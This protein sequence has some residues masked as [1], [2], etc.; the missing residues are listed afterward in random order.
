MAIVCRCPALLHSS[1]S[2]MT[3]KSAQNSNKFLS[4]VCLR[5]MIG[6]IF[7]EV[8]LELRVSEYIESILPIGK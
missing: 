8:S 5:K 4:L 2:K 7:S 1:T 3:D 6:L